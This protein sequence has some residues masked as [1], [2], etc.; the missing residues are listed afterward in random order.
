ME[1][2]KEAISSM[3]YDNLEDWWILTDRTNIHTKGYVIG[4]I[5]MYMNLNWDED[6][7]SL[8]IT[9]INAIDTV[10]WHII[11]NSPREVRNH[12]CQILCDVRHKL[13]VMLDAYAQELI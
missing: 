11:D 13:E 2:T 9:F 12:N 6:D 1:F 5:D 8:V 7:S 3:I 4:M 10:E